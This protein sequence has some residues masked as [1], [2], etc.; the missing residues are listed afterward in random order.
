MTNTLDAVLRF[1]S[2]LD[3]ATYFSDAGEARTHISGHLAST[4]QAL[5]IELPRRVI[6]VFGPLVAVINQRRHCSDD[7]KKGCDYIH[8]DN[9][10]TANDFESFTHAL[11]SV[12]GLGSLALGTAQLRPG[13]SRRPLPV[14][15]RLC[16]TDQDLGNIRFGFLATGL[17]HIIGEASNAVTQ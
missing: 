12:D 10:S 1:D 14:W 7:H 9:A 8:K 3:V 4:T 16:G 13:A 15:D 5:P 2:F 6:P 11:P 17:E